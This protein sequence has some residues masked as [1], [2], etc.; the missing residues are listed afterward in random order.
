MSAFALLVR[1]AGDAWRRRPDRSL[2]RFRSAVGEA[3]EEWHAEDLQGLPAWHADHRGRGHQRRPAGLHHGLADRR[4]SAARERGRR[5][6]TTS[7]FH[8]SN[9]KRDAAFPRRAR[10][11]LRTS[12]GGTHGYPQSAHHVATR[13][14]SVLHGSD[15]SGGNR[16]MALAATGFRRSAQRCG[17][18]PWRR[19]Q[20][21][22][23]RQCQ[24]SRGLRR[25]HRCADG[26]RRQ[27]VHRCRD[28]RIPTAHSGSRQWPQPR[29]VKHLINTHWHFDHTDGN[30]WLNAEGAAIIAHENTHKHLLVAQR[31]EDWDFNFPSSP[32][33]AVPSETFSS[34]KTLNLNRSTLHL[35]YYGPAHTDSDISVTIPEADILHCADIWNGIYP[36]IDYSTGGNIDGMI[37]ATDANVA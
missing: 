1:A 22:A 37:K 8:I 35:K 11:C 28:H 36:F 15:H 5:P 12:V 4:P 7:D 9:S 2:R 34:E 26:R 33:P 19:R 17:P 16:R 25:Q 32:L 20:G 29:S 14:L 10:S 18:Y 3:F 30:Q 13:I 21:E 6:A 27:G 23:A 24:H 31:V